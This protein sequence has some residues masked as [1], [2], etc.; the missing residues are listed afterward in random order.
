M[1]SFWAKGGSILVTSAMLCT[2]TCSCEPAKPKRKV[3]QD[4]GFERFILEKETLAKAL[5][6]KHQL[7]VRP[8][9]WDFFAAVRDGDWKT[10]SNLFNK[11]QE[12]SGRYGE[13]ATVWLS[14]HVWAPIHDTFGALEQ[15]ATWNP[16]MLRRFGGTI[17]SSIP[18]NSIYF[19]GTDAGRFV[20]SALSES[21]RDGRP[22]FTLTQNAL[23]DGNYLDYLREL[24]G[25]KI[26]IPTSND[27]VTVFGEYL[28]DAQIRRKENRLEEGENVSV[29]DGR[30]MVT[31]QTAVMLINER[32]VRLIID[33][34]PEREIYLEES[35]PLKGLYVHFSPHG[36]ILKVSRTPIERLE[37]GIIDADRKFWSEQTRVLLGHTIEENTTVPQLC[38]RAEGLYLRS[39]LSGVSGDPSYFNDAQAPQYFSKCRSA[40]ASLYQ[41]R[42]AQTRDKEDAQALSREAD[43]AHR[44][45]IALLPYNVE[46]V[47]N[48]VGYLLGNHRT[49]DAR[50]LIYTTL[51]LDPEKR[52]SLDSDVLRHSLAQLRKT[53]RE[54]GPPPNPR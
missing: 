27:S 6:E 17:I 33:K 51:K 48:Y 49:N 29:I 16:D 3:A 4:P 36:M 20:I 35:I 7:K 52:M 47:W 46:V 8:V 45:A 19:G 1:R 26:Y 43:L 13:A 44:Q 11:L 32:L 18:S 50:A 5:A 41:W 38:S 39:N 30:V 23:A 12:G 2:V 40:I 21:H 34:N 9:V 28:K 31:G 42:S 22:F 14:P 15:F 37:R 53:E 54:L 10:S 25:T 24:Y